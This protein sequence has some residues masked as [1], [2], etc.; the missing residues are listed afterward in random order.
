[1]FAGR[2]AGGAGH[3]VGQVV[4]RGYALTIPQCCDDDAKSAFAS[5]RHAAALALGSNVP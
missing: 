1:M 2:A 5:C 4:E 3:R